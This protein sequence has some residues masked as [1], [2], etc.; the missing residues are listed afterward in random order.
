[1]TTW[2]YW[3]GPC[4]LWVERCQQTLFHRGVNVQLLGP[5][6]FDYLRE[7]DRD[8]DL[9]PLSPPHRAD[10]IR[11]YLLAKFGG[12]WLDSDCILMKNLA[13]TMGLASRCEFVGYREDDGYISNN[14]MAVPPTS[15]VMQNYYKKICDILRSKQPIAWLT[16]GAYALTP[17]VEASTNWVCLPKNRIMPVNWS[18][19]H[20]FFHRGDE[21]SHESRW[22]REAI[23]YMMSANMLPR[24]PQPV[25]D[26]L[27]PDTFFSF[28]IARSLASDEG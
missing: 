2:L 23:C 20:E 6:D 27:E 9:S 21:A 8:I 13:E 19:Q 11:A 15:P 7:E 24:V 18:E 17:V 1:M 12:I 22:D 5:V 10:F 25:D 16:L 3:E 26:L 28:L 4:P 14:F